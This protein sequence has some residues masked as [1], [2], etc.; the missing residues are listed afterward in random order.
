MKK[1]LLLLL[2][3]F[4]VAANPIDDKCPQ[5]S[6]HGAPVSQLTASQYLCKQN[7][8]I[9]YRYDTKTAE[10]VVEHVS[11]EDMSGAV[12]RQDDFHP[13]LDVPEQFRSTLH[14]YAGHPYDRGHLV[15]AGDSTQTKEIMSESFALTNMVPQVPA[16]NRGIW[17]KLEATVRNWAGEGRDI[18][19]VSGTY[20]QPGKQIKTIGK[21]V[22][23][24]DYLWKVIYDAT[25]NQTIAFLIPNDG[26]SA[27]ELPKFILTVEQL[28]NVVNI[29][30]FPALGTSPIEQAINRDLWKGL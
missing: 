18:Y 21:G 29:N 15:P 23:I 19:V 8:A 25:N 5:F 26:I 17:N 13:D 27:R 30:F 10:Y 6:I 22:A 28:Q 24:P 1:L 9:H 16:N 4:T 14:D 11:P 20:H 12:H 7:Y 2:L 3:P